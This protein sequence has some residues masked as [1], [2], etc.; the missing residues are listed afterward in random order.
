MSRLDR[1]STLRVRRFIA[2]AAALSLTASARAALPALSQADWGTKAPA[3]DPKASLVVLFRRG[4]L[5]LMDP[6]R[7]GISSSL[8]LEQRLKV[9]TTEGLHGGELE[10]AHS[11]RFR[12]QSLTGRTLL[13]D[14]RVLPLPADAKFERRLS[15]RAKSKVTAVAFPGVEVGSI[16][17]YEAVLR[18]ESVFM[19][20]PWYLSAES[21]VVYSE[22]VFD[23]PKS[24]QAGTWGR[25]PFQVGIETE[26][27]RDMKGMRLR[28][29]ARNLPAVPSEPAGPPFE[30]LATQ[31]GIITTGYLD[32]SGGLQ[33]FDNWVHTCQRI[34]EWDYTPARDKDHGVK[35]RAR[36]LAGRIADSRLKAEA[37]YRFVRD[38]IR[39]EHDPGVMLEEDAN[40]AQVLSSGGGDSAEKALLLQA[41]L[42]A[43]GLDTHLVWANER[44]TGIALLELPNP[45][46]F[47]RVL[48]AVD[49]PAGRVFLDPSEP[50]LAFGVLAADVEGSK[51]LLFDTKLPEVIALPSLPAEANRRSATL[52]LALDG[53][54]RVGGTGEIVFGGQHAVSA[55]AR[56]VE[57]ERV[58][59]WQR[60]LEGRLPGFRIEAVEASAAIESTEMRLSWRMTQH[61]DE[62]LGD[63]VTLS[64]SRPLGPVIQDFALPPSQRVTPV[65]LP[66]ADRDELTLELSFPEGWRVEALPAATGMK[67][68]AGVLHVSAV[69]DLEG[70]VVRYER[71]LDVIARESGGREA[72]AKLQALYAAAERQDAKAL[73]LA[74]R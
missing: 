50:E 68:D 71:R 49:L 31:Y 24:L 39:N 59:T 53:E 61:D 18:F 4:E 64:P 56:A 32:N 60:W 62:V 21:P 1:R 12:L 6:R 22:V 40:L 27:T 16:V 69:A 45:A 2:F 57:A 23:V 74:R 63:E 42:E 5:T 73:S 52:K 3:D 55:I 34:Q 8:H 29:W 36:E 41:M 9:L 11:D 54:G 7:R 26:T 48:V 38:Q 19:L 67:N 25:D 37:L 17:E 14:G 30:D 35:Q 58:A 65:V 51:A 20:E 43:V 72:Y 70:R 15:S 33:L 10:I 47:E 46:W 13:P 66:F 28:A 44:S